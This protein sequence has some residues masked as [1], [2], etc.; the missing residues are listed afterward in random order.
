MIALD[1]SRSMLVDDVNPSRLDR[2]KLMIQSLLD[3]LEGERVGLI[4]FAGTAFLQSP[5]SADPCVLLNLSARRVSRE[6][7]G[8]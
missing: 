6:R 1:L 8:F 3:Y 4:V 2:S 7:E 5:L